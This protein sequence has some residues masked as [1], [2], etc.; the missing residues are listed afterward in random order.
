MQHERVFARTT[1]VFDDLRIAQRAKRSDNNCLSLATCE[2]RRAVCARQQASFYFDR[3]DSLRVATV[4]A[5]RTVEDTITHG[6]LL[7]LTKR[8]FNVSSRYACFFVG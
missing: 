3:A 2:E 7:E 6:A 1:E 4:D 5:R 8:R